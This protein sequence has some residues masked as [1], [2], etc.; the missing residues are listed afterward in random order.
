MPSPDLEPD[1]L[2]VESAPELA[3]DQAS[4]PSADV[5]KR[6][7]LVYLIAAL[8][9]GN[10]LSSAFRLAGGLLQARFVDKVTLGTFGGIALV[11]G[12]S[13][14]LQLGICNGLSRELPYYYGKGDRGKAL[15]LAAT[16]RTW[17]AS[18]G[19]LVACAFLAMAGWHALRG[20]SMLA[21]G[22]G[23][24]AVLAIIFFY[25]TLYLQA[26][27]RT[28]HD[29][30]R[31]STAT[32]LQNAIGL[33]LVVAVYAFGFNGLCLR[34]VIS[35]VAGL[36]ILHLWQ[37]IRVR[38][39]WNFA[40]FRHLLAIGFPIF[41]VGEMGS[42]LWLLIDNTLVSHYLKAGGLGLY[43]IVGVA[44]DTVEILPLAVGQIMYPRMTEHFGRT[45]DL[46]STITMTI[47]PSIYLVAGMLPVVAAGWFLAAPLTGIL[48][49]KY[50]E[51]VPAMRW[52][53]LLPLVLSFGCVH[54][55]YN[56]CR[57]QDL[58][59]VIILLSMASYA[60]TLILLSRHGAYLEA[61]PQAL[62]VGR[63]VFILVGYL[64]LLPVYWSWKKNRAKTSGDAPA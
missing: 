38:W 24:H 61:F 36:A 33:L 63:T 25:A 39:Q 46:P 57:R 5:R 52:S 28:A 19:A 58:Y 43:S 47:K 18:M 35:G 21:A 53:I 42:R 34:A 56:I 16:A 1:G 49:P 26:T 45:H 32:T 27:Y 37:P 23:A 13:Y 40:D 59:A 29:F 62:L 14:Y 12:W 60:G 10:L 3:Q 44:R 11:L 54:N 55:V 41:L 64:F 30:A 48:L 50:V 15:E 31:L 4:V 22:W 9:G 2:P 7:S 20:N 6:L 51:A 8:A 17:L